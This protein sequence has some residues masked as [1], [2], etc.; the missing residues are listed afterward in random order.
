MHDMARGDE[1][2]AQRDLT[3]FELSC[4][5]LTCT[6]CGGIAIRFIEL[7]FLAYT[8]LSVSVCI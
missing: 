4:A 8:F 6:Y 3:D 2:R 1:E 7:H 5:I